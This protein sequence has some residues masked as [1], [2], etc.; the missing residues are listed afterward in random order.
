MFIEGPQ[1][2]YQVRLDTL[3]G[4][5]LPYESH[6]EVV[7]AHIAGEITT[8]ENLAHATAKSAYIGASLVYARTQ[9]LAHLGMPPDPPGHA[10]I[11]TFASDG[12]T[13]T[14][15]AHYAAAESLSSG[16]KLEYRQCL[17][18]PG[19]IRVTDTYDMYNE[20]VKMLRNAQDYAHEQSTALRDEMARRWGDIVRK[21]KLYHARLGDSLAGNVPVMDLQ[22]LE[23]G[24]L[25]DGEILPGDETWGA[26]PLLPP[27]RN[28]SLERKGKVGTAELSAQDT[29]VEKVVPKDTF[30]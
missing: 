26:D 4:G 23:A 19:T 16:K 10:E 8:A 1:R 7:L 28:R 20:C 18:P 9:A 2:G 30:T 25:S 3:T 29:Q 6:Y 22:L 13:L 24:V 17:V 21:V 12:S 14:F 15:F 5:A 27:P 11:V